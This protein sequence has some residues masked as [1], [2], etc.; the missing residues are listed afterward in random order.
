MR[1]RDLPRDRGA[2][3]LVLIALAMFYKPLATETFYFRDLHLLFYPKK[4]LM[5]AALRAGRIPLWDPFTNGGQPY[6]ALPSN[7]AFHPS[8]VLYLVV[9]PLLAFNLVLVL[10]V[11]FCAVAAYWAARVVRLT[12]PAAFVAGAIYAFCGYTLSTANL[13]PLLLGLPWIPM[14]VGLVHRALRDGRSIVPAAFAA[15]MPLFGAAV[16]LTAMLFAILVVWVA[17]VRLP[18]APRRRAIALAIVIAGAIGLS[19]VVTL[20]ATTIIAESSRGERRSYENF[21]SWSVS[22]L[23]LPELAIPRFLGDPDSMLEEAYWGRSLETGRYPYILS[24]SIGI[25]ALLL[26]LTGAFAGTDEVPRRALAILALVAFV[27]SLGRYLP[28]FRAIY[29]SVPLV[30]TFRFPVKAQIAMLFPIAMLAACGVES[31]RASLR[32]IAFLAA[33]G[34]GIAAIALTTTDLPASFARVFSFSAVP[35]AVFVTGFAHAALAALALALAIRNKGAIAAVVA[36]DLGVA[37]Y[38]VNAYASRAIFEEPPAAAAVREASGGL[39]FHATRRPQVLRTQSDRIREI[40]EWDIATLADYNAAI[41]GVP[42][43]YHTDYDGLA[44]IRMSHLAGRMPS[45]RWDQRRGLLDRAAVRAFLTPDVVQMPGIVELARLDA[46]RAPLRLYGNANAKAAR[47]VGRT[48]LARDRDDALARVRNTSDL[49]TAIVETRVAVDGC[50][51]AAVRLVAR[52]LSSA[53]YEVDAPCRGLVVFAENHVS[54]WRATVDGRETPHI[55]ADY[56]FTAVAVEQGRHTIERTYFPPRLI[57]GAV[58]TGIAVL[59]LLWAARRSSGESGNGK[60]T[61][62]RFAPPASES[63]G[64]ESPS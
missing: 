56:A 62:R 61:S 27:L 15:A 39:R 40:A 5:V 45:L 9:P 25:P 16:E 32:R 53:R 7:F 31:V 30:T 55:R 1:L 26:A 54:G 17:F 34:T 22:P 37:G 19:L 18:V 3:G 60:V 42:V 28:G 58:G 10:H 64:S 48:T 21:A 52:S 2:W 50:S 20:P 41:F 47:F 24:L 36:L 11:M 13:T 51:P 14:T 6:L 49:T 33:A 4:L 44:P 46:P 38:S 23:R 57:G 63:R 8:N 12:M 29:D 59:M 35:N 43:V